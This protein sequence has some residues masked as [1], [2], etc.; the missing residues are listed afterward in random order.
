MSVKSFVVSYL[1]KIHSTDS[2]RVYVRNLVSSCTPTFKPLLC[3]NRKRYNHCCRDQGLR[4]LVRANL[5]Q[6]KDIVEDWIACLVMTMIVS[7]FL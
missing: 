2:V 5:V 4:R 7:F 3:E 6:T 1:K